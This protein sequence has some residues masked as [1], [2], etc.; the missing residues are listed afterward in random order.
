MSE[1]FRNDPA[2]LRAEVIREATLANGAMR[3]ADLLR[4][5]NERLR[6]E[7]LTLEDAGIALGA[8]LDRAEQEIEHLREQVTALVNR[9][10]EVP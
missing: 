2:F 1:D 3:E 7:K 6:R 10:P 5:E 8:K 9:P 4:D